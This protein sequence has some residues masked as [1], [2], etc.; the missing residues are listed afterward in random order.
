M[1]DWEAICPVPRSHGIVTII[2]WLCSLQR[3]DASL[4]QQRCRVGSQEVALELL[5][6]SPEGS[7][8]VPRPSLIF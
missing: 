5:R 2:T 4:P 8:E 1:L 7:M 6:I 3:T